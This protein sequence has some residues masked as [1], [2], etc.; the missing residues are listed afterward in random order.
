MALGDKRGHTM[1]QRKNDPKSKEQNPA[2]PWW[3]H[4]ENMG[5]SPA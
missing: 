1:K 2:N 5:P 4:G 3:K